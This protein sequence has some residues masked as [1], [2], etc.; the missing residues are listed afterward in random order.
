MSVFLIQYAPQKILPIIKIHMIHLFLYSN[1]FHN[2][3][4]K[5]QIFL[6]TVYNHILNFFIFGTICWLTIHIFNQFHKLTITDEDI[7]F[8]LFLEED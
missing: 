5:C 8:E 7:I 3:T 6:R 4:E 1:L 2:I